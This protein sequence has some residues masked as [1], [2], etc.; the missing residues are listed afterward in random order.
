MHTCKRLKPRR[1]LAFGTGRIR[2]SAR[3]I[4]PEGDVLERLIELAV[5]QILR[6][7][8]AVA[9][10]GVDEPLEANFTSDNAVVG[11]PLRRDGLIFVGGGE[12]DVGDLD[13]FADGCAACGGV[14]EEDLVEFGAHLGGVSGEE[15]SGTESGSRR[16]RPLSWDRE[17]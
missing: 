1:I 15:H 16:S 13:A 12:F 11:F 14:P 3:P 7:H 4:S 6:A 9:P 10:R 8:E 5:L 2:P 17:R